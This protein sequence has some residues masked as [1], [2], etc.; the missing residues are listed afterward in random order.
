MEG[1]GVG[2]R[3]PTINHPFLPLGPNTYGGRKMGTNYYVQIK[4]ACAHCGADP[5][6]KHIGKNSMGWCFDLHVYPEERINNLKDWLDI[7][8]G[9]VIKDEYENIIPIKELITLITDKKGEVGVGPPPLKSFE[10]MQRYSSWEEF[11]KYNNAELSPYGLMWP[12]IGGHCIGHGEDG[13]YALIIG[14][15]S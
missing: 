7:L 12:I 4:P 15:F 14:Y 10:T 8:D 5:V 6:T 2:L 9:K 1:P 11:Y 13:S 3:F